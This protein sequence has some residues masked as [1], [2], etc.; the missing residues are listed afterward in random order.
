MLFCRLINLNNRIRLFVVHMQAVLPILTSCQQH[1]LVVRNQRQS[2]RHADPRRQQQHTAVAARVTSN[3]ATVNGFRYLDLWHIDLWVTACRTTTIEYMCTITFSV[4]SSSR[5]P[6]RART[7]RQKDRQ[8]NR[9]TDATK[10]PTHVGGY[11]A[12]VGN[13]CDIIRQY[14]A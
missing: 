13:N 7:N 10:L 14:Q 2:Y 6:F 11:T 1:I 5:F 8:T 9:Q 3:R 4:D 12:G